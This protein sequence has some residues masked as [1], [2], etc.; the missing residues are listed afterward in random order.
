MTEPDPFAAPPG[1]DDDDDIPTIDHAMM[2]SDVDFEA[3]MSSL[4]LVSLA[5]MIAC[6]LV[7]AFQV[8]GGA[9]IDVDRLSA[10]GALVP[11]RVRDGEVWRLVSATFLHGNF[12][13]LLGNMLML[14]ILGMACEHAFGRPQFILLYVASG[15]FGSLCSL[16]GGRV[17]VGASGAIFG[18]AGALIVL[19]WRHRGRL[20]LRDRR[21]GVVLA[22]WAGYQFLLGL[23]NPNVDNLA[24]LGGLLGGAALGLI[25]RPAVLD[26]RDE[27]STHPVSLAGM[28]LSC[29][30]LGATALFFLP[31][32]LR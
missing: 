14:F 16:M 26:G 5:L 31:R 13:H 12:D 28:V 27:V 25:L 23:I 29:G 9:R 17:S 10:I 18:L 20:H 24:H 7:F 19:F 11:D 4:P 1:F 32:L 22:G 2:H 15:I 21:I 6:A 8:V 3:G 30:G